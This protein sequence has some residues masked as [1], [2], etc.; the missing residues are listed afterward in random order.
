[1]PTNPTTLHVLFASPNDVSNE[2]DVVNEVIDDLNVS[3]RGSN[4]RV[5]LLRWETHSRPGLGSDAQEVINRQLGDEYDILIGVMWTRFGSPTKRAGS[6]TEEEFNLAFRPPP[7]G[8]TAQRSRPS[9]VGLL[10]RT[11][12]VNRLL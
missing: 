8:A 12:S 11:D 7:A 4:I 2:R 5:E 10:P 1:M 6:G 3:L 9:R